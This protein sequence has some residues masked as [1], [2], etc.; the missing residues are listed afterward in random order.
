MSFLTVVEE[1][2]PCKNNDLCLATNKNWPP[3]LSCIWGPIMCK[4]K[5]KT[6]QEG[7]N[8]GQSG[9][10]ARHGGQ[11]A[12]RR[13]LLVQSLCFAATAS[14]QGWDGFG[15]LISERLR[16]PH[17]SLLG[18]PVEALQGERWGKCMDL[19]LGGRGYPDDGAQFRSSTCQI[20]RQDSSVA[21]QRKF[22][23]LKMQHITLTVI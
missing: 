16:G 3:H 8:R 13:P 10:R 9:D 7:I 6:P 4:L 21:K 14:G 17:G 20:C 5:G 15:S 11:M 12:G 23:R 1:W 18:W 22:L 19:L 2:E